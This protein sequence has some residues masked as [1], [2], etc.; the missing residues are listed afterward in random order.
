MV[1]WTILF[2]RPICIELSTYLP[3]GR[4]KLELVV[5]YKVVQHLRKGVEDRYSV[6]FT[7]NWDLMYKCGMF[8][9][10]NYFMLQ[11]HR[12]PIGF[13]HFFSWWVIDIRKCWAH[14]HKLHS[15]TQQIS[16]VNWYHRWWK[17]LTRPPIYFN[18]LRLVVQIRYSFDYWRCFWAITSLVA[19]NP[20][21]YSCSHFSPPVM[22]TS[23]FELEI[24]SMWTN[25]TLKT[26]NV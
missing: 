8:F 25:E 6:G 22:N 16:I 24:T 17:K 23:Q 21:R 19:L 1:N 18:S 5:F 10:L 13:V 12:I 7:G 2:S 3:Y 15:V 20:I 11:S 26:F 4:W 14:A 9:Y